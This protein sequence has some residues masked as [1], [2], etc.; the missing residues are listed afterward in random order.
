MIRSTYN[1]PRK[2]NILIFNNCLYPSFV[3]NTDLTYNIIAS[4]KN[5][6]SY[7]IILTKTIISAGRSMVQ[8]FSK[9]DKPLSQ[10]FIILEH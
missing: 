2:A 7:S 6:T 5:L 4:L 8:D 9:N 3:L 1:Y 10:H